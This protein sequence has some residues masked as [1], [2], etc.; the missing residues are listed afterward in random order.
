MR[1]FDRIQIFLS[2]K[3]KVFIATIKPLLL[4]MGFIFFFSETHLNYKIFFDSMFLKVHTAKQSVHIN[5]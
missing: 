1:K 4:K 5:Y 3:W 2:L